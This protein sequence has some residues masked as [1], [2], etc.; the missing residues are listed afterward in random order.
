MGRAKIVKI[1]GLPKGYKIKLKQHTDGI[2]RSDLK[3]SSV[4]VETK[5]ESN[6]Q[7]ILIIANDSMISFEDGTV[8][9]TVGR[10]I[11]DGEGTFQFSWSVREDGQINAPKQT[12]IRVMTRDQDS[13][14]VR[15]RTRRVIVIK[16]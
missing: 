15:A 11:I 8:Q 12:A 9:K 10:K 4:E 16:E 13:G 6:I 14:K 7:L 2:W 5:Y 3:E 1:K